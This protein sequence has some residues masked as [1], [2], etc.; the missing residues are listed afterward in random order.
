MLLDVIKYG[1]V[2]AKTKA[3]N[4]KNLSRT[5]YENLCS[6]HSVLEATSYLKNLPGYTDVFSGVNEK[7]LHRSEIER[8]LNKRLEIYIEKLYK[9]VANKDR[10]IIEYFFIRYEIELLKGIIRRIMSEEEVVI[11]KINAFFKKHLAVNFDDVAGAT[12]LESFIDKLSET[13]YEKVL[14]PVSRTKERQ[15]LFGVEMALDTYYFTYIQA[16]RGS[17]AGKMEEEILGQAN[18]T[19]TDILNLMWIYRCKR[20]TGISSDMIFTFIIP[21]RYKLKKTDIANMVGADSYEQMVE[22]AKETRYRDLFNDINVKFIEQNYKE[23]L[24]NYYRKLVRKYPFSIACILS[25]LHA[26]ETE[27]KTLINLIE[28]LRYGLDQNELRELV[29]FKSFTN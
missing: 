25:S 6:M 29:N 19:E 4:A 27:I 5:D 15:T 21:F 11:P 24:D 9:F 1:G 20:N 13:R 3:M 10:E 2:G 8:L 17:V 7:E 18:G 26:A 23:Y 16:T 12:T 28:G 14:T 22:I